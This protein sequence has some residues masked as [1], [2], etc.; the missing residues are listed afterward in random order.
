MTGYAGEYLDPLRR[1]VGTLLAAERRLRSRE[2]QRR[3]E[4]LTH[5]HLRALYVLTQEQQATAGTL[6][7]AA[8]LNPASVTAMIDQ[9]EARGLVSRHRDGQDRRQCWIS[10]TEAGREQVEER[11]R[12]WRARM[13]ETF[14]DVS[15]KDIET[16]T[17]I[18]DRLALVLQGLGDEAEGDAS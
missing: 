18:I 17:A 6:A 15:R 4:T 7:K 1:S 8:D 16:A 9:L 5:S 3:T 13:T 2:Q 12:Y 14:A 11:E 10:L